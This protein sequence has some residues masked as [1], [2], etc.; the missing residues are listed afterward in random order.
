[1]GKQNQATIEIN[2][3]RYD[4][5]TGQL[6]SA[7]AV[8]HASHKAKPQTPKPHAAQPIAPAKRARAGGDITR[9]AGT[10]V[11]H[12]QP[13]RSHTLMRR[14]VKK[15][16]A[17]PKTSQAKAHT[18]AGQQTT[19][20][21]NTIPRIQHFDAARHDRSKSVQQSKLVSKFHNSSSA[22]HPISPEPAVQERIEHLPVRPAPAHS[23]PSAVE[24]VLERGL[25]NAQSHTETFKPEHKA[26]K[27]SRKKKSRVASYAAGT[28]AAV[29]LFGFI[30]YQNIPNLSVRY[31]AA[32]SGVQASLPGYKPA[33]FAL[34]NRIHYNPGQIT[35]NFS[36]N[37]DDRAFSITQRQTAWNSEALESNYVDEKSDHVQ[38]YED[39][40]R[41][42]YLYDGNNATWVNGGVWYDIQ[43]NSQLNSDQLI[44]IATSM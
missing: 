12:R 22:H 9:S 20:T 11:A 28:L 23:K 39:R 10:S 7:G 38:K 30:S 13:S 31:A 21:H 34:S 6:L 24:S 1:M 43:G 25:R 27:S 16:T 37:T 44:R 19:H 41:T 42:I 4:A 2:G 26:K 17:A 15:P 3:K 18:T 14:A 36:S 8:S 35:I 29:L 32:R 5:R 33:G 40:G